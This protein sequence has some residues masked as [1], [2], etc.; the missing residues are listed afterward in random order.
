VLSSPL[1]G[2]LYTRCA[3]WAV[4][5]LIVLAALGL[6]QMAGA[7]RG[8]RSWGYGIVLAALVTALGVNAGSL[9]IYPRLLPRVERLVR[10]RDATNPALDTSPALREFQVRNL[11]N[12]VSFRNPVAVC[13]WLGWLALGGFCLGGTERRRPLVLG[14]LVGLNLVPVVWFGQRFIPRQ[15]ILLWERLQMGGPAQQEVVERM[16]GTP[17]RLLERAPGVHDQ[18][19]PNAISHLYRVRTVHGY[20]ALQPKCLFRLSPAELARWPGWLADFTYESKVRDAPSGVLRTNA[21]PGMARFQWLGAAGREFRVV[22]PGLNTIRLWFAP[23]PAGTLVWSDTHYPGWT[24][25]GESGRI[26][27]K[28][29]GPCF[30]QIEIPAD[31]RE[32]RLVYRPR[33][34][35]VGKG[36]AVM[37]LA[38]GM[39]LAGAGFA[40]RL[41]P[42]T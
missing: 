21:T 31:C 11:P 24:A 20:S 33:Y 5:G 25:V 37:S 6:E 9:L 14:L 35:G 15:S 1:L 3:A 39:L 42:R 18:L 23:G 27:I 4:V 16:G 26:E 38:A 36:L 29:L 22:E 10:Q 40:R 8:W 17:W 19:F 13:S 30:S 41:A 34:L 32:L 28:P 7:A 2:I 12:E